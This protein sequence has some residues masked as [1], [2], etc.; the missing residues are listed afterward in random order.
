LFESSVE[1]FFIKPSDS[2]VCKTLKIEIL[3]HIA[4]ESNINRLLKEFKVDEENKNTD[5]L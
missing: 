4:N 3:I 1:E 5:F 2:S